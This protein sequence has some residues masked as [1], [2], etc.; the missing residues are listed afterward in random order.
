MKHI[1]ES[2]SG[3]HWFQ[4]LYVGRWEVVRMNQLLTVSLVLEKLQMW[5]RN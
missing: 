1:Q 4:A 3:M 2:L 5:D